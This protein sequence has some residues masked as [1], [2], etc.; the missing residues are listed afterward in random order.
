[1]AARG[2]LNVHEVR[3][4]TPQDLEQAR[5]ALEAACRSVCHVAWLVREVVK[6]VDHS[7]VPEFEAPT[8]ELIGRLVIFE[9]NATSTLDEM[10]E[11]VDEC[12]GENLDMLN[13]LRSDATRVAV[14]A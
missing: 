2:I 7:K 8:F 1:M 10:R 4:P 9:R 11:F 5:E 13:E 12:A 6:Y 14:D 3:L